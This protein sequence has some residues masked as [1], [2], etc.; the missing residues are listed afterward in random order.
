MSLG[1]GCDETRKNTLHAEASRLQSC[2]VCTVIGAV[3]APRDPQT[4]MA[5]PAPVSAEIRKICNSVSHLL[6]WLFA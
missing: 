5:G 6:I 2:D 3:K 4:R 1:E